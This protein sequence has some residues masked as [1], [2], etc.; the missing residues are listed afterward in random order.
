MNSQPLNVNAADTAMRVSASCHPEGTPQDLPERQDH[1]RLKDQVGLNRRFAFC[2]PR[3]DN[4]TATRASAKSKRA[5]PDRRSVGETELHYLWIQIFH[6]ALN[7]KG[8]AGFVMAESARTSHSCSMKITKDVR[9]YA[10]E[11]CIAEEDS[12][13]KGL[14]EESR[15]FAEK[16]SEPYAKA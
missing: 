4:A 15:E 11:H 3:T 12:S 14:K 10:A 13:K 6:S 2:L 5:K 7:E 1:E 8:R 16:G 9:N